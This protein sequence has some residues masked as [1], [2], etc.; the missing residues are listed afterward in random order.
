M[1]ATSLSAGNESSTVNASST[2]PASSITKMAMGDSLQEYETQYFGFT[3]KSFIDGVY[4]ALADYLYDSVDASDKYIASEA[5]SSK[6]PVS[7]EAVRESSDRLLAHLQFAFDKAFDRLETYLMKNIFHIPS[8]V[9]LPEDKIHAEMTVTESEEVRL[10]SE[11]E[12]LRQRIM[13]ARFVNAR[14]QQWSSDVKQVQDLLDALLKQLEE[15]QKVCIQANVADLKESIIFMA[16]RAQK[17]LDLSRMLQTQASKQSSRK[18]SAH[19]A[20]DDDI[21]LKMSTV[22]QIG[23]A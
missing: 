18:R 10:D 8:H 21:P 2:A 13:N 16:T 1:D 3:P 19:D 23:S 7:A 11:L 4:N 9:V 6:H 14:L 22:S 17:L 5:Q 15:Y 12:D 20:Q